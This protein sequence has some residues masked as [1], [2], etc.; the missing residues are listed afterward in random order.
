MRTNRVLAVSSICLLVLCL[1]A[2]AALAFDM[3]IGHP[4]Q[5]VLPQPVNINGTYVRHMATA[6][7]LDS[8]DANPIAQV[9]LIDA[10]T[11]ETFTTSVSPS[12][13]F[14]FAGLMPNHRYYLALVDTY[15]YEHGYQGSNMSVGPIQ[16]GFFSPWR[17]M[18][19]SYA[20]HPLSVSE[21]RV[22]FAPK[23][24]VVN[25]K[26]SWHDEIHTPATGGTF[27]VNLDVANA[28]AVFIRDIQP[29]RVALWHPLQL[30]AVGGE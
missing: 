21:T 15:S 26:N 11:N 25:V 14:H 18:G 19:G 13:D 17:E 3:E 30:I 4:G 20:Q 16:V 24:T 8:R 27:A 5:V 10:T 1:C 7:F 9:H 12:G 6:A 2:S 28:D 23:P 22:Q 29:S